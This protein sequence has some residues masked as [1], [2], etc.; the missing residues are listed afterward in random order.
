MTEKTKTKLLVI[1][2][3]LLFISVAY[4]IYWTG[5]EKRALEGNIAEFEQGVDLDYEYING[6]S[7][8]NVKYYNLWHSCNSAF[9]KDLKGE[10]SDAELADFMDG[11]LTEIKTIEADQA[12]LKELKKKR[13]DLLSSFKFVTVQKFDQ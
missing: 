1:V 9:S 10:M 5:F 11:Y 3:G 6:V 12:E 13:N 2:S 8:S 7:E 4:T